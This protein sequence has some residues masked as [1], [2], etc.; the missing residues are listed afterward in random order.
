MTAMHRQPVILLLLALLIAALTT[1]ARAIALFDDSP[2]DRINQVGKLTNGPS[3][4]FQLAVHKTGN[5]ALTITNAGTFGTGSLDLTVIDGEIAPSCEYP[6]NSNIEYLYQGAIWVGAVVGHDTLVSVGTDGWFG[7]RELFPD[8]GDKGAIIVRSNLRSKPEYDPKA[9][10][11]QD[12]ISTYTD[13]YTDIALTDQDPFDNRPHVPLNISIRQSSYAW[14]YQ[15][16]EDFIIFDYQITNI[17]EFPLQDLYLGIYVDGAAYHRSIESQGS[18]DDICGFRH[19]VRTPH[20]FCIREDTVNIAWIADNDG[21]PVD[22]AWNFASPTGVTGVRILRPFHDDIQ[23]SFNWWISNTNPRLDF[24]PRMAG[25]DEDPFRNFGTNIGTPTG[26]L[27]KYYVLSHPEFDY[28]QL[29]SAVSH[30]NQGY[31]RPASPELAAD[32]ADGYDTRYLL[33]CGPFEIDPGDSVPIT[34]AYVAGDSFHV[35][36][37]DYADYFD[38]SAPWQ[39]YRQLNFDDLGSNARWA[40]WIFDNP[41]LDTD[42][43][44]DSG[45]YCWSYIWTDTTLFN[46]DSSGPTDSVRVDS[47]KVFYTGDGVPDFRGASPPPPP[48]IKTFPEYSRVTLRWNGQEAETA[49]DVFSGTQDFEG[50]RI[51]FGE[52]NRQSDFILHASYDIEDYVIYLFDQV[53]TNQIDVYKLTWHQVGA[54]VTRD[55][56]TRRF[57]E[58]FDPSQYYDEYHY[59]F[60]SHTKEFFFLQP[61]GWNESELNDPLK[62]HKVYPEASQYDPADTTEEG[63]LRYY[64]YEYTI[65]NLRPSQAYYFSVT[66]FDFGSSGGMLGSLESSPLVNAVR[67]YPL[68]SSETVKQA[69]LEVIVYPN[70]YRID[71]G[72]ARAGYENRDR[73]RSA[74]WSRRI[75]FANLPD[76]CT[77]RIFTLSGDLVQEIDHYYPGGGPASQHEEWNMVSRNTQA[78]VTGI[79]IWSVTSEMGEQLGKLVII[80]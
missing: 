55:S 22:G 38:P 19:T 70:P 33:S 6:I 52:N 35:N 41:G 77:I 57:G 27:N 18:F 31:L 44:G 78:I 62:I 15:Y 59:F 73:S 75:H 13:T 8:A 36:P 4:N 20:D 43:N 60:D 49:Y 45:K 7:V 29:F 68:T 71:A 17:G 56:L 28:D 16:A 72:Y 46:P 67:E 26:D 79:Y 42:N 76:V 54:P 2:S 58:G 23:H 30:V 25:T 14:S 21:D 11:E 64:E 69:G 47:F 63:F 9:I 10:S 3:P 37:T 39:Y 5:M 74:E 61:Q 66:T 34:M 50:Y 40:S 48:K 53:P 32:F 80:K 65:D 51:Y 1:G 12:F 24:G